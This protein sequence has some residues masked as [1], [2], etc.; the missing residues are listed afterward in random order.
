MSYYEF[1]KFVH[2]VMA[3]VWVGGGITIQI[4]AFKLQKEQNGPRMASFAKD[5][6]FLGER[7]FGPASGVLLLA[8]ILM[9]VDTWDF[10]DTFII[11][12][13]VGFL[14]TVVTGL[15]FLTP[16]SKKVGAIIEQRGPDDPEAQAG[17]RR[18][19]TISRIDAVVLLVVIFNM[20]TK[21][22]L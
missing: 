10:S 17:I 20:V 12:G 13:I 2:V 22:G 4:L 1:L 16:E 9:V 19:I 6:G 7:V 21:P 11:I 18:L 5:A 8:G 3:V 15:F 14:A